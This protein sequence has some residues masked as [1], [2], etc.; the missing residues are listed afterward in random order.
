MER[1]LG[2][3]EVWWHCA[4]ACQPRLGGTSPTGFETDL[5]DGRCFADVNA[6]IILLRLYLIETKH[7]YYTGKKVQRICMGTR[8]MYI[9]RFQAAVQ[10][11]APE[12]MLTTK[13]CQ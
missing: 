2:E 8:I 4:G 9:V 13:P 6:Y 7:I 11:D 12:P 1:R 10:P 3:T 5:S